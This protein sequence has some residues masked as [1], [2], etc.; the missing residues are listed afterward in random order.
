MCVFSVLFSPGGVSFRS[1]G[2]EQ[3]GVELFNTVLGGWPRHWFSNIGP[4]AIGY[5]WSMVVNGARAGG[6]SCLKLHGPP[7]RT[8][9]RRRHGHRARI[10]TLRSDA[11]TGGGGRRLNRWD[12]PP[13]PPASRLP[14]PAPHN[15]TRDQPKPKIGTGTKRK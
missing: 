10:K 11:T 12:P 2:Q 13:P 5:A 6:G 8:R 3:A 7:T 14:P 4:G 1:S 9:R 15:A